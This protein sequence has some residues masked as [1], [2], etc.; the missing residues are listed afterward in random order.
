MLLLALH[1]QASASAMV[2]SAL[3]KALAKP[4]PVVVHLYDPAGD[5]KEYALSTPRSRAATRGPPGSSRCSSRWGR[6]RAGRCA[7]LPRPAALLPAPQGRRARRERPRGDGGEHR[8]WKA[9]GASGL[10]VRYYRADWPD[11]GALEAE[12][13]RVSPTP[14]P[15]LR[16]SCSPS[17][18]RWARRRRGAS[19]LAE[20]VG[21]AAALMKA[22]GDGAPAPL[23]ERPDQDLLR[24]RAGLGGL[25]T[26]TRRGDIGSARRPS[27][28]RSPPR[29]SACSSK[30][31]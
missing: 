13:A 19:G 6:R 15:G 12:L 4:K 28:R 20:R 14:T 25:I 3:T 31:R 10:G 7:Q 17:L 18:G 16:R 27:R 26:W 8:H 1:L 23:L 30:R 2:T 9:S 24:L 29:P 5:L 21:A 22:A 11:E